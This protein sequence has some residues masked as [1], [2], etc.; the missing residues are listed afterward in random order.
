[1]NSG[2]I[3]LPSTI[4]NQFKIATFNI[5]NELSTNLPFIKEFFIENKLDFLCLQEIFCYD[6][7]LN[8]VIN[9]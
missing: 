5:N 1:L 6:F 2:N 9:P 3:P 8:K 4:A 7:I